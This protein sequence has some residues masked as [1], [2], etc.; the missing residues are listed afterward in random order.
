MLDFC[1][2]GSRM[3]SSLG[4]NLVGYDDKKTGGVCR[5]C[6]CKVFVFAET[7]VVKSGLFCKSGVVC[8]NCSCKVLVFF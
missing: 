1:I 4:I 8:R 7:V 3:L 5:N 6:S 2:S